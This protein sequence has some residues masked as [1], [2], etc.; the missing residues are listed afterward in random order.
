MNS[1]CASAPNQ[2]IPFC[3]APRAPPQTTTRTSSVCAARLINNATRPTAGVGARVVGAGADL[4]TEESETS[5]ED[6]EVRTLFD[7]GTKDPHQAQGL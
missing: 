2:E 6:Y 1:G 7:G 3:P 5:R 4:L